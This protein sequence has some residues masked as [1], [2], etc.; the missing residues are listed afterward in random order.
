M[1]RRRVAIS[2]G[3]RP[4]RAG[5]SYEATR[6][7]HI[8]DAVALR[9]RI[10]ARLHWSAD[11]L[12]EHR[13]QRLRML[14]R[15]AVE[16]SP[17]HRQRLA[18][19]DLHTLT[20]D[21]LRDLPVMTKADV[22][23][24]FDE[25]VTDRRLTLPAVNNHLDEV[26]SGRDGYL[27]DR[28]TAI[29]SGGSSG[30]RGVFIYD[31]EAWAIF[32]LSIERRRLRFLAEH[33]APA[34]PVEAVVASS[35]LTH[36]S[37]ASSRT[38]A[39]MNCHPHVL[40]PTRPLEEIVAG[41]NAVQPV[42]LSG[43]A[44]ALH[45]LVPEAHAGRLRIT[46]KRVMSASEPLLPHMRRALEDTWGVRVGNMW[47][48]SEGGGLGVPCDHSETHLS[49]D[50]HIFEFVDH[51][52]QPVAPRETSARVLLTNLYNH[53]Q[54]LIRYEL[55][56]E[57]AVQPSPCPC[58]SGHRRID[59]IRGRQEDAFVY[60][61]VTVHPLLFAA[62]LEMERTIIEYQVRQTERGAAIVVRCDGDLDVQRLRQQ[63][64]ADLKRLGVRPAE[65]SIDLV[66]TIPRQPSGKLKRFVSRANQPRA[67]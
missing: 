34:L 24:H 37:A 47:A 6:Q 56:D 60:G 54:P 15:A 16:G 59:D 14:V 61:G 32:Y 64:A 67:A 11:R 2:P 57:V 35:H 38:F 19:V 21:S 13:T 58:G 55:T 45:S 7:L 66:D 4:R 3:R 48:A 23:E 51:D 43:Y 17:W 1:E 26:E 30:R 42:M 22:M 65:V 46:P 63:L 8:A 9:P 25:V 5:M 52:G 31:W 50:L 36:A 40:P 27:L 44:S 12:A 20:E 62:P 10:A 28:Y 18:G 39:G 41:L 53:A 29:T 49:E 33:A